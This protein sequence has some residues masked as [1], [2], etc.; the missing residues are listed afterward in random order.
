M[1][2]FDSLTDDEIN[3][4][5]AENVMGWETFVDRDGW[6]E[7]GILEREIPLW[8][9]ATSIAD[10]FEAMEKWCDDGIGHDMRL[11]IIR[12][13]ANKRRICELYNP[14]IAASGVHVE[15]SRAIS[16]A[17]VEATGSN[18]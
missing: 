16:L 1:G 2:M 4:H 6:S 14:T 12:C 10:A 3:R 7:D 18:G 5:I 15:I 13:G 17:L 9:P 8:N 11:Y